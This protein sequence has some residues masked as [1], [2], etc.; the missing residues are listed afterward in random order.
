MATLFPAAKDVCS[1]APADVLS[2]CSDSVSNN[3]V[4]SVSCLSA[5]CQTSCSP[6]ASA[7][8]LGAGEL[9]YGLQA[10]PSA[11]TADDASVPEAAPMAKVSGRRRILL[12]QY[13]LCC[14]HELMRLEYTC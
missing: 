2:A 4:L 1:V 10:L 6:E 9:N 3:T 13:V 12:Q 8:T 14:L 7:V 11:P 5:I